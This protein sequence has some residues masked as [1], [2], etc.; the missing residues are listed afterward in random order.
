MTVFTG[1]NP[2]PVPAP[3]PAGHTQDRSI[4]VLKKALRQHL[5]QT[6]PEQDLR[7]WYDPLAITLS[8]NDKRLDVQFPHPFFAQWFSATAQVRFE[9]RLREFLGDGY[10]LR[11][12]SDSGDSPRAAPAPHAARQLD[13]PFGTRFTFDSFLHNRKNQFPVATAR[14][15]AHDSRSP[16]ERRYNPFVICGESGN[17][18][19]HLLRAIANELSRSRDKNAIFC[20]AVD[21]LDA[22]FPGL[23]APGPAAA[24]ERQ[25]ARGLLCACEALVLDDL[26]RLRDQPSMQEELTFAFDHFRDNGKQMVFACSGRLANL[27]FLIPKLRSRLEWGLIVELHEP[28]LDVRLKF[29]QQQSRSRN[30]PLS[31]EHALT[32][33]QRFREFRHLQGILIKIDAY[34]QL[35]KRDIQDRELEQILRH[36]DSGKTT[37]L[38]PEAVIAA[39]AEHLGIP[40]RD[41]V[42]DK[43]RQHIVQ[44]RQVAMFLCRELLGSSFPA[45]GRVFGGKD[46]STAM[47]AVRKIKQ[48]QQSD[49]DLQLLVTDIKRKCLTRAE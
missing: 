36:T 2:Y 22:R 26:Q 46:H 21:E 29:V 6:C 35:I 8:E 20:D 12:I 4:P 24:Q 33:A 37:S 27:N 31:K 47:Y 48:L 15:V 7:Q 43:R 17:G 38:T 40:P 19:T 10:V 30:I 23:A 3:V 49:K 1:G 41:I 16:H 32:L 13:Y 18:K 39:T 14:E 28:D 34:R 9:S 44:A 25:Q 5:Q 42:G 45:L 11:Y